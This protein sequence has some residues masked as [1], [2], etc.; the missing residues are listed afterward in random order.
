M[1]VSWGNSGMWE[2]PRGR[3]AEHPPSRRPEVSPAAPG[4]APTRRPH[5]RRDGRTDVPAVRHTGSSSRKVSPH[6]T[7]VAIAAAGWPRSRPSL[8]ATAAPKSARARS[9]RGG[10]ASPVPSPPRLSRAA[11]RLPPHPGGSPDPGHAHAR[12]LGAPPTAR[13]PSVGSAE[14]SGADPHSAPRRAMKLP[15]LRLGGA[16]PPLTLPRL[17]PLPP[18]LSLPCRPATALPPPQATPAPHLKLHLLF[19]LVSV[20]YRNI[21]FTYFFKFSTLIFWGGCCFSFFFL[22]GGAVFSNLFMSR[23]RV[24][25]HV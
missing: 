3:R 8:R 2:Q 9:R 17:P 10:G 15:P 11:S 1:K 20:F 19:V 16:G 21:F 23:P 4:R 6:T 25:Q 13:L 14:R 7:S 18:P 12:P 5:R 24:Q 22:S